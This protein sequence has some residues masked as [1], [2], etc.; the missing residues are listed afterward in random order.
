[1]VLP[2]GRKVTLY[3]FVA[4]LYLTSSM[5]GLL[6]PMTLPQKLLRA[7]CCTPNCVTVLTVGAQH[8][9]SLQR[10]SKP[11]L[12]CALRSLGARRNPAQRIQ[13]IPR[14]YARFRNH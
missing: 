10:K 8:A 9:A 7:I 14:A 5:Y 12:T 11:P 2:L 1:M 4:G 3:F 6:P 13:W